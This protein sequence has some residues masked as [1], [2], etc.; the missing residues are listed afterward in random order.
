[1]EFEEDINPEILLTLVL[2]HLS[3]NFLKGEVTAIDPSFSLTHETIDSFDRIHLG[4]SIGHEDNIFFIFVDTHAQNS[5]LS[6]IYV[7]VV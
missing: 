7:L 5:I 4:I 6:Q 1:M 2:V 3:L